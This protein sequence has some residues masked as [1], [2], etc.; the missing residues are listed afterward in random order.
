[1]EKW[2]KKENNIDQIVPLIKQFLEGESKKA[3][4]S[5]LIHVNLSLTKEEM[6]KVSEAL[7]S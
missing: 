5:P 6:K 3:E 1:M 7:N 2:D 4:K